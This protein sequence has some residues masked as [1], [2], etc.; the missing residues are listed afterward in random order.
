[1]PPILRVVMTENLWI[2]KKTSKPKF[3]GLAAGEG[4]EQETSENSV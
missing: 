4:F 2:K 3:R 1:M